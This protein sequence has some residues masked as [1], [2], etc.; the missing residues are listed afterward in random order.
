M[1][2]AVPTAVGWIN[3]SYYNP[4]II[5]RI[6]E[7]VPGKTTGRDSRPGLFILFILRAKIEGSFLEPKKNN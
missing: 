5:E 1:S 6:I 7:Y 3:S 2:A 4:F